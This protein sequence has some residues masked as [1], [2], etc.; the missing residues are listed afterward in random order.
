VDIV[1]RHGE[2]QTTEETGHPVRGATPGRSGAPADDVVVCVDGLEQ[3]IEMICGPGLDRG[4]HQNQRQTGV[5]KT[6]PQSFRQA[7][8]AARD[9]S[10]LDGPSQFSNPCGQWGDH[11]FRLLLRQLSEEDD[12]DAGTRKGVALNVS[13]EGVVEFL[14]RRHSNSRRAHTLS[15]Q[16]E[17]FTQIALARPTSAG[18]RGDTARPTGA[19]ADQ[20]LPSR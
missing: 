4:R 20:A 18:P 8:L 5:V 11:G 17:A 3:R 15:W 7:E 6:S 9:Y 1:Q 10:L 14:A 12:A 19:R 13:R 2:D 16:K